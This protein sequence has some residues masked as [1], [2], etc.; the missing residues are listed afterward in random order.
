MAWRCNHTTV[1]AR[2]LAHQH[3]HKRLI[4]FI[5]SYDP[6]STDTCD[7]ALVH[8]GKEIAYL[9]LRKHRIDPVINNALRAKESVERL[10][11]WVHNNF[12]PINKLPDELPSMTFISVHHAV[13]NGG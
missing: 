12:T 3:R 6:S 5:T 10:G 1:G 2:G 7:E 11:W 13:N 9:E 8:L 4:A